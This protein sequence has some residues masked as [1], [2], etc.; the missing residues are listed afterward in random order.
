[1]SDLDNSTGEIFVVDTAAH[2]RRA[3]LG[4]Y[5]T[6]SRMFVAVSAM[7]FGAGVFSY[8]YLRSLNNNHL[9]RAPG[10]RPSA[11]ISVPVLVLTLAGCLL[12]LSVTRR[13]V[14][15]QT[16]GAD[17]R[18]AS[19]VSLVLLLLAAVLQLW[20]T[21]RLHF[22]PGSSGYASVYVAVMPLFGLWLLIAVY[23]IEVL[24]ARSIRVRWVLSPVGDNAESAE[25]VA[26]AGSLD[27]SRLFVGF[28]VL[29][30][31]LLYVLFSVLK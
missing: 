23:W 31:V 1:M 7:V 24:L 16:G 22:F 3:Q 20:G 19:A 4:A 17:W 5:W 9:W 10:Q 6:G 15:D 26:F 25:A 11:F 13:L 30:S 27:G 21:R 28:I 8:F 12:Y 14:R 2:E 18:V 29:L